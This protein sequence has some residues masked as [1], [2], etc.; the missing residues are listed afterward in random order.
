MANRIWQFHFGAGLVRTPS[1]FGVRAG[2]PSNP[3]L[4]DWLAQEFIARKWSLKAMHRLIMT[5]ETYRQSSNPSPEALERDPKNALLSHM[6]RRRLSSEELRDS[7]LQTVGTLNL[8]M[9]G[10]PVVPPLDRE[11]LYGITGAPSS[12]WYVTADERE[13]TRRSI[14]LLVRRNFRQPMF[15]AFDAPDGMLSCSRRE[16][17]TTATQSLTLLNGRFMMEQSRALAVKAP[18]MDEMWR[19][20]YGRGPSEEERRDARAF[21]E[22][23]AQRRLSPQEALAELARAL[24]NSN[25][26]LYVD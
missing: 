6:D 3:D 21:L 10:I 15:E 19:R 9:G 1:D 22:R 8:K 25:E 2:R 11:E 24:L 20:A 23:Q 5:S 13:H 16:A 12:S 17:S 14:Y 26:F 7:V 4:L 18:D